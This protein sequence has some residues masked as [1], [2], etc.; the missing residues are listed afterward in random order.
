[1]KPYVPRDSLQWWGALH[2]YLRVHV[3]LSICVWVY[4]GGN[5][6]TTI[7]GEALLGMQLPK[8]DSGEWDV[9]VFLLSISPPQTGLV[10]VPLCCSCFTLFLFLLDAAVEDVTQSET[11]WPLPS[12]LSNTLLFSQHCAWLPNTVIV[13]IFSVLLTVRAH[14][15]YINPWVYFRNVGSIL[16]N[17][18]RGMFLHFL[19]V[20]SFCSCVSLTPCETRHNGI[21]SN[22]FV[23]WSASRCSDGEVEEKTVPAVLLEKWW[24]AELRRAVLR[25]VFKSEL[26]HGFNELSFIQ[27]L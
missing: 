27:S 20:M 13:N 9:C 26:C 12:A 3:F 4:T 22:G 16:Q 21:G 11:L 24:W 7:V 5:A 18:Q 23:T 25:L 10:Q 19:A 2:T 8:A 14:R 15:A 6:R 17:I 1:M